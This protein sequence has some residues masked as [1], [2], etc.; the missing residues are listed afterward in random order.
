MEVRLELMGRSF[1]LATRDG[2]PPTHRETFP[3]VA[4]C[5]S[6]RISIGQAS[7][8]VCY[9]RERRSK[10]LNGCERLTLVS[11][12]SIRPERSILSLPALARCGDRRPDA[13]LGAGEGR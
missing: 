13:R 8:S 6:V 5:I 7:M 12:R 3:S 10:F 2:F 4:S 9:F 1:L 11:K